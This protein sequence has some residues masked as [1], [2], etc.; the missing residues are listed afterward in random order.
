MTKSFAKEK[1]TINAAK[2]C[3]YYEGDRPCIYNK[4][5]D[6]TCKCKNYVKIGKRIVIIKLGA[7]GDVIRTTP[8]IHKLQQIYPNCEIV[9]VTLYPE[10]VP[11]TVDI[12][13][14]SN[15]LNI[16]TLLADHFDVC[17]NFD[18]GK[19]ACALATMINADEKYGFML[20]HFRCEPINGLAEHKFATGLDNKLYQ[21][22]KF[23]AVEEAFHIMGFDYSGERYILDR[24]TL[25][26]DLPKLKHPVVGLNTGCSKRWK[27]EWPDEYWTLL[28]K[29]LADTG[30]TVLL[31]GGEQE[32]KKNLQISEETGAKYLGVN[33]LSNFLGV[34]NLCDLVVSVVTLT[35]HIA[36][37]L[38][39]KVVIINNI[40]NRD[41]FE[42]FGLGTIL[43]PK[44]ECVGTFREC[45]NDCLRQITPEHVAREIDR[46][47]KNGN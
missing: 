20:K 27:R 11:K 45:G 10:L 14:E 47:L 26:I 12:I 39:K 25:T 30:Y 18:K 2:D 29:N 9:W 22:N 19:E 16:L 23:S 43:E 21:K 24:P 1:I 41:E 5:D 40:F 42:L 8:I 37:A 6:S 3:K 7:A 28:A 34:V 46:L 35:M 15:A 4:E 36:M 17:C 13:L 31:L 32:H 38:E 44:C 33:S